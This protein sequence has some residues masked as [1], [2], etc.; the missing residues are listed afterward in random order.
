MNGNPNPTVEWSNNGQAITAG[1]RVTLEQADDSISLSVAKSERS[2]GGQ[3]TITATNEHGS[4]SEALQVIVLD[5]PT[6]PE[7]PLEVIIR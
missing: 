6:A 5:S 1:P 7:G 2:D 3:Y 4:C